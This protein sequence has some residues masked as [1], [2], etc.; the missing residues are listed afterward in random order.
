MAAQTATF[1]VDFS[2][3]AVIR[4]INVGQARFDQR[5][6]DALAGQT[7]RLS[8]FQ[9]CTACGGGD[10]RRP[11]G[12]R[13]GTRRAGL[14]GRA[15]QPGRRATTCR[16]ARCGAAQGRTR[17]R[18]GPARPPAAH[19]G[20][21]DPAARR[22]RRW[23]R[24]GSTR[25][26]R[27]CR[28][29]IDRHFGGDP[30]HLDTALDGMPR[31]GMSGAKRH[32]LVL[33]RPAPRRHRLPAPPRRPRDLPRTTLSRRPAGPARLPLPR[34]R[35]TGL[36][37]LPAPAHRG[38]VHRR[39][40]PPRAGSRSSTTC[41][42]LSTRT[43]SRSPTGGR[44]RAGPYRS[45]RPGPAGRVR[46][47]GPLPRGAAR[48]GPP[49]TTPLRSTRTPTAAGCASPDPD[50]V[51]RWQVTRAARPRPHRC[52]LGVR[53]RRRPGRDGRGLP[54]R[55]PPPRHAARATGSPKTRTNVR[56]CA[57]TASWSSRSP[58]TT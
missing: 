5:P 16:G 28:L 54:R 11:P 19:R 48:G 24:S 9:V 31:T 38:P 39:R 32:Y 13:A 34:G 46:P 23:S 33:L 8:P 22:D 35:P 6:Q 44:R 57:A 52:R 42:A 50:G 20:A 15:P 7:V 26:A 3:R 45:D 40:V 53:P 43:A 4:R 29:G 14:L 47:G 10:R 58:G 12:R 27:R 56:G 55:P 18:P 25:S 37:P 30:Q 49:P 51:V 17:S 2:R 36:P 1:G 41:W 21:A